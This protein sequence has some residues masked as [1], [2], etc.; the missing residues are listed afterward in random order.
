M[1]ATTIPGFTADQSLGAAR[2]SYR[3][4]RPPAPRPDAV[5]PAIPNCANCDYILD[6]CERF[7][8][9]PRGLCNYCLSGW[10]YEETPLPDPFPD[11]FPLR[12][13]R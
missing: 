2:G 7:G 9:R 11:P 6:N 4:G 13:F 1:N 10:C 3:S 8:W 12:R 5:F